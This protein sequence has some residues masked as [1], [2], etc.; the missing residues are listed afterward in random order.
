M[1][2]LA[3]LSAE[4]AGVKPDYSE[5]ADWFRKAARFGVKDSQ[6]NLGILYARGMGIAQDLSQSWFWFSLAAK[7]GDPD[8]AK[9]RDEVAAKMDPAA[10]TA[11]AAALADFHPATPLPAANDVPA[12]PGGWDFNKMAAPQPT[13]AAPAQPQATGASAPAA[14]SAPM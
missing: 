10:L 1:H 3:V 6:Y 7:Q 9:K 14:R 11:D 8:A 5:A 2:N 12:P 13:P 4:G